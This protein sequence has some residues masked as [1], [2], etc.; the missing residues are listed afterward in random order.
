MLIETDKKEFSYRK[1]WVVMLWAILIL[2]PGMF[3]MPD[4][5][6]KAD[7]ILYY[8]L[9]ILITIVALFIFWRLTDYLP[10]IKMTGCYYRENGR[11]VLEYGGEKKI[12]DNVE[13]LMLTDRQASSRGIDL[14]IRNNGEKIDFLSEA[15]SED[16]D[17]ETTVFYDIFTQ[18][19]EENPQLEIVK[20]IWG[21][22]TDY[23]Y[24]AKM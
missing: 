8:A 2:V 9:N 16:I 18:V 23:W 24:K 5:F 20:D 17:I 22:D 15:L 3:F 19:L 1:F 13:E 21:E 6:E 12:L 10:G 14:M 7:G 4:F 11:T